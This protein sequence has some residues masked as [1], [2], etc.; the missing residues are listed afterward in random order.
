M[1]FLSIVN[2]RDMAISNLTV[3]SLYLSLCVDEKINESWWLLL[4]SSLP[5]IIYQLNP[6]SLSLSSHNQTKRVSSP[7]SPSHSLDSTNGLYF[8]SHPIS[9]PPGS[10][11]LL[12]GLHPILRPPCISLHPLS[13][14]ILRPQ[15]YYP[16]RFHFPSTPSHALQPELPS[17]CRRR[18]DNWHRR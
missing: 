11:H 3:S 16:T 18:R 14:R 9:S 12:P 8:I 4:A 10:R 7:T 1:K 5:S 6:P 13:P 2:G 17:P 15:I